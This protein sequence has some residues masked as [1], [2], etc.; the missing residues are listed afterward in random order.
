LVSFCITFRSNNLPHFHT[1]QVSKRRTTAHIYAIAEGKEEKKVSAL[2]GS[3][4]LGNMDKD[5][6]CPDKVSNAY[7][8]YNTAKAVLNRTFGFIET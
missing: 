6:Y 5:R 7:S 1:I 3:F 8:I 2:P 4:C